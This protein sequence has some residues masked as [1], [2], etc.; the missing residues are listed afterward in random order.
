MLEKTKRRISWS[1]RAIFY[2]PIVLLFPVSTLIPAIAEPATITFTEHGI[3]HIRA[4][5]FH[6]LGYGYAY[7]AAR[8]DLCNLA[9]VFVDSRGERAAYLG[10]GETSTSPFGGGEVNDVTSDMAT[11]LLVSEAIVVLQRA[12]LSG[13]ARSLIEGYASGYNRYLLDVPDAKRPKAC[14]GVAWV[15]PISS[16][17]ILRRVASALLLTGFFD[18]E[19][20]DAA[21]PP[22]TAELSGSLGESTKELVSTSISPRI[23]MEGGAGSNAYAFGSMRTANGRGLLLGNPHWFWTGTSRFMQAHLTI[24]G[25][26]DVMGA[27]VIGM[28]LI[29]LGFNHSLAWTHTVASD[30][31]GTV[32]ELKL[33]PADPTRYLVDGRAVPI[34]KKVVAV[35]V[36]GPG[37][38]IQR[39]SHTFWMTGYGPIIESRNLP[40]S[41]TTA[42]ALSDANSRNNRYLKQLLQMGEAQDVRQLK[43]ALAETMG[44]VWVNT[45]A[46]DSDGEALFADFTVVPDVSRAAYQSCTKKAS[47]PQARF[48]N[49]MDGSRSEC[50]WSNGP[51]APSPGIM[52]AAQKPS[53]LTRDYVENSNSSYWLVNPH[54]LLEGF[55]PIMGDERLAPNIRTLQAHAQVLD[56]E[57]NRDKLGGTTFDMEKLETVLFSNRDYLAELVLDDL[58]IA[59]TKTPVVDLSEGQS[60]DLT[61]ACSILRKWDRKDNLDSV[62]AEIFREFAREEKARGEED[63]A[64]VNKFWRIPFDPGQPLNTPHGLDISTPQPLAALARGVTRLEKAGIPL[65]STLGSIQFIERDG[66]RIPLHGGSIF[67]RISLTLKP[68]VGYTEPIGSAN[69]YI[70]VVTFNK[71]GPIADVLLVNSQSSDPESPWYFDQAKLYSQKRWVRAPFTP[72][73]ISRHSIGLPLSLSVPSAP[74]GQ[75]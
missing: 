17:D 14:R 58:L 36:R 74:R 65:D 61:Q 64:R 24:P 51:L 15:K 37:G 46:A 16:D 55:S 9:D 42:Y 10:D 26:Y 19:L 4:H 34:E 35:D 60:V 23:A 5:N 73:E 53:L 2:L 29:T 71:A 43:A 50:Q 69:S 39:V 70:Q 6:D 1:T 25:K 11:Q 63:P 7:A 27:S 72:A 49:V 57:R 40:W 47:F 75:Q 41:R 28:P 8:I 44:L 18:Q 21:P 59:C 62:G 33:D 67:N 52:P 13:D 68:G 12:G 3:P 56:R 31:R 45:I 48:V 38:I 66:D 54:H 30:A 32:Y 20:F 22:S